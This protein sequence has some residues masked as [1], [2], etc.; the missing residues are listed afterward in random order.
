MTTTES[1]ARRTTTPNFS[2][3]LS[4]GPPLERVVT[5]ASPLLTP[6][7]PPR[8]TPVVLSGAPRTLFSNLYSMVRSWEG[9]PHSMERTP[10]L[11]RET[12]RSS[13]RLLPLLVAI[14]P[15]FTTLHAAFT[16]PRTA[17]TP[18]LRSRV[19]SAQEMLPPLV[20]LAAL[21]TSPPLTRPTTPQPS[22]SLEPPME[23]VGA[24]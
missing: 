10:A 12:A 8:F 23:R 4:I 6:R 20:P 21:R 7:H 14:Q 15:L 19:I 16:K 22:S 3:E 2:P 9:S 13:F 5:A 24:R 1:E 18:G 11:T 17:L